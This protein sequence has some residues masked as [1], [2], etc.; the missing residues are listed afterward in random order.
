M[1]GKWLFCRTDQRLAVGFIPITR[2]DIVKLAIVSKI[3]VQ[4]AF[5]FFQA[6]RSANWD[7]I[8]SFI[9]SACLP[10]SSWSV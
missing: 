8:A 3:H 1:A 9:A 4:P 2:L 7:S 10:Y 6:W 5:L